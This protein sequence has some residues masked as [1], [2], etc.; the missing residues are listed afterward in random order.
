[1]CAGPLNGGCDPVT[2]VVPDPDHPQ[3][4]LASIGLSHMLMQGRII[5]ACPGR[6]DLGRK[7]IKCLEI[8]AVA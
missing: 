3:C 8:M 4:V 7:L 5:R 6:V 1:L 2:G